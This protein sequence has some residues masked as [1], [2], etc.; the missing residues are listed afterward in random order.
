MKVVF[1][2]DASLEIGSGHVMRCLTLAQ[3]L[4]SRSAQCLF[5]CREHGGNM[6]AMIRQMGFDVISL[7]PVASASLPDSSAP[8]HVAWVGAAWPQDAAQTI[9]T[10]GNDVVDWLVVDH[11]GLDARWERAL[12][13]RALNIM[14]ID[15]L[16]DRPHDCDL[17]LDQ[18]LIQNLDRRYDSLLPAACARLVG[19]RYA[20]L[21]PQYREWQSRTPARQGPVRRVLAYFGAA[22]AHNLSGLVVGAFVELDKADVAL[23]LVINPGSPHADTV[24]AQVQGND[25][26]TLH[27]NLPSLALLMVQADLAIGAGGATS[28]ERCCLGL[29]TLV[30][31]LADN[32]K[33]IA[34][35]L[36]HQGYVE[37]LGHWD[38]VSQRLLGERL[39]MALD[40]SMALERSERCMRLVDGLGVDRVAGVLALTPG[41]QLRSRLARLDD[42]AQV[43]QCAV[44]LERRFGSSEPEAATGAEC[45]AR[46]RMNLRN[47]GQI[48]HYLVETDVGL[49]VGQVVFECQSDV[50]RVHYAIQSGVVRADAMRKPVLQNALLEFRSRT[51]GTLQV[52]ALVADALALRPCRSQPVGQ[53]A[54]HG[55]LRIGFCSDSGSWINASVANLVLDLLAD[56]HTVAWAHSAK[57]L[58][59][60]DLCFYLSYGRIVH[61]QT[62][63][64]YRHNLVV[65]ASDLPK[66]RGWS[67]TSWL[68]LE[69]AERIPVTLLEAVDA[70]DAGP[71]YLQEWLSLDGTELIDEW[72]SMLA[73]STIR[74]VRAFVT[75]FP[76]V[77]DGARLQS[78]E[79]TEYPRRRAADSVLDPGRS[80]AA[81]F[82]QL[83]IVDNESYPAFFSQGGQ[84]FEL[85]IYK[86]ARQR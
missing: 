6:T 27:E 51:Q 9:Q 57:E 84:E 72:R 38:V 55:R 80:L 22:D 24:R 41:A 17:L 29:P 16:A 50:W 4:R 44:A 81:Q 65:H 37:W 73:A 49:P 79:P 30:V 42:E 66:G 76:K 64:R 33:P 2:V 68:I 63:E 28:W 47:H 62:R 54:V 48:C 32:Q 77:L 45:R 82:N 18:N 52:G 10:L 8:A 86:R 69:G 43:V 14:V 35:E 40:G 19:P 70:V 31:T 59:P 1:R 75:G 26:I 83:R 21:Q 13:P 61:A 58:P 67:P 7:A 36:H 25:R 85:K 46:F 34:R 23:D 15:D 5:V 39:T 56:G 3:A 20:L 60:G 74:L 12:R 71:I 11:Y 78:G 53:P